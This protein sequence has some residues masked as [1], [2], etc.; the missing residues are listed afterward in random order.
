MYTIR[1]RATD[2]TGGSQILPRP[3]ELRML[4]VLFRSEG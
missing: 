4:I 2:R 3:A 1:G